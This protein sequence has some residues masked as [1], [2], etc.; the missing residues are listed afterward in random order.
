MVFPQPARLAWPT[1]WHVSESPVIKTGQPETHKTMIVASIGS[2]RFAM[3]S[4][5]SFLLDLRR[6]NIVGFD[7]KR[8]GKSAFPG[9]VTSWAAP[10]RETQ[11]SI[12][13]T[14]QFS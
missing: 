3:S 10:S 2:G 5:S 12:G 13:V 1:G 7:G 6:F 4:V 8:A 9:D 14:R 11:C